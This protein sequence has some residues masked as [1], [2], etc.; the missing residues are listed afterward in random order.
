M[1]KQ[2]QSSDPRLNETW[3]TVPFSINISY[4]G[5]LSYMDFRRKRETQI[6]Q[7]GRPWAAQR[8]V[9]MRAARGVAVVA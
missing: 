8:D 3:P 9:S 1:K 6:N 4:Y 2:K 5:Q 7:F